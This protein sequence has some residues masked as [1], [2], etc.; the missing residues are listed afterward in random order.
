M[1]IS[2]DMASD[3]P[4]Y[5]HPAIVAI[6]SADGMAKANITALVPFDVSVLTQTVCPT[7]N[8]DVSSHLTSINFSLLSAEEQYVATLQALQALLCTMRTFT[9]PCEMLSIIPEW[10][11]LLLIVL[12]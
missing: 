2:A 4:L 7:L 1:P 12:R 5:T 9:I 11:I 10:D 3:S 8:L 6:N